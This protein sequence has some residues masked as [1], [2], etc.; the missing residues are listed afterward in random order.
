MSISQKMEKLKQI[1]VGWVNYFGIAD[2]GRI[3]KTL[4]MWVRRRVRMC[5]WKQWKRI[6]TKHD[7]L[8]SLGIPNPK[9][10]E[11]ANTRKS[12][13]RIAGSPILAK[14]LTNKYLKKS[15]LPSISLQYSSVH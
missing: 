15:G 7:N 9:A 4:D 5:F 14:A 2:M 8:V 1:I 13:W 3:A 11:Y 10:W 6:K 12:Y